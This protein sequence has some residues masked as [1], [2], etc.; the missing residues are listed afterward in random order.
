MGDWS[1]VV[2]R[3]SYKCSYQ[4]TCFLNVMGWLAVVISG[5]LV[6]LQCFVSG[7]RYNFEKG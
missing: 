6:R 1:L 3:G 4:V 2:G 5:T 7:H